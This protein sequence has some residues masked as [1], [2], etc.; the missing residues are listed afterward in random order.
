[1]DNNPNKADACDS[2]KDKLLQ[3]NPKPH[4]RSQLQSL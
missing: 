2:S 3:I 4:L 1:M